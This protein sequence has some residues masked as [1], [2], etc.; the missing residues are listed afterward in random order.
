M[1]LGQKSEVPYNEI[2]SAFQQRNA[3]DLAKMTTD[4]LMISLFGKEN[5]YSSQQSTQAIKKLFDENPIQSFKFIFK[6][7]ENGEGAF[8][9]ANYVSKTEKLRITFHF[10][11]SDG[12][13]KIV[14]MNV[15][16]E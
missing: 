3:V 2:E 15:E 7:K 5:V 8:A 9:I 6:G 10:K 13:F 4:K 14:R 12:S 1:P 16:K 11:K